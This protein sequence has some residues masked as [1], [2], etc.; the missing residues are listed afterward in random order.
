MKQK[1]LKLKLFIMAFG[2]SEKEELQLSKFY[3]A[4]QF[5]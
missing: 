4:M 5:L 3:G 2:C 1:E